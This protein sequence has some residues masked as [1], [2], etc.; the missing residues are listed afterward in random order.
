MESILALQHRS[1]HRTSARTIRCKDHLTKAVP[2]RRRLTLNMRAMK[3][4]KALMSVY[5]MVQ[6]GHCVVFDSKPDG[7]DNSYALHKETGAV[8]PFT[9]RNRVWEISCNVDP[10]NDAHSFLH[11][12]M[13][14][15]LCPIQQEGTTDSHPHHPFSR[16]A[17]LP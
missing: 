12:T 13:H 16:P 5:E 4:S 17:V 3:V 14:Q 1:Y 8:T 11:Q 6:A 9:L 2:I 7:S 10:H 15:N